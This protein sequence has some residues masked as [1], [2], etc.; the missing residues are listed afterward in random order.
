MLLSFRQPQDCDLVLSS[1]VCGSFHA[2]FA[3]STS[4]SGA[5]PEFGRPSSACRFP[6]VW[7]HFQRHGRL[8]VRWQDTVGP[9]P[10]LGV[11]STVGLFFLENDNHLRNSDTVL[12][13]ACY[14]L[15][16]VG[17]GL[18]RNGWPLRGLAR[19]Q[20][21]HPPDRGDEPRPPLNLAT[22]SF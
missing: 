16:V 18:A 1:A 7:V 21:T 12:P 20:C 8:V 3:E 17:Y 11:R 19:C 6:K 4:C 15:E 2:R 9:R 5:S 22:Q 10:A 13:A 14:E